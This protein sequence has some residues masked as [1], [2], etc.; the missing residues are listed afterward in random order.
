MDVLPSPCAS[1]C[2]FAAG[3]RFALSFPGALVV[4]WWWGLR[5]A[6]GP[7]LGVGSL[8][9]PAEGFGGVAGGGSPEPR[10]RGAFSM[11]S[12][13]WRRLG[14]CR[15][16]HRGCGRGV[17]RRCGRGGAPLACSL[18]LAPHRATELS[19]GRGGPPSEVGGGIGGGIRAW[20]PG[21]A[22][23]GAGGGGRVSVVCGAGSARPLGRSCG[24]GGADM[25][26][27]WPARWRPGRGSGG[28]GAL[29][30]YGGASG[31]GSGVSVAWGRGRRA[32]V[33]GSGR[34]GGGNDV[35]GRRGSG[36]VLRS[37][38][39]QGASQATRGAMAVPAGHCVV[40]T[41][42]GG[43][44]GKPSAPCESVA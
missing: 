44:G 40:L 16:G 23:A 22:V 32:G 10:P 43:G 5:G 15:W 33:A 24:E 42:R 19:Q 13:A 17:P 4:G 7:C 11:R 9:P 41:G 34:G 29:G 37:R 36:A 26:R 18:P 30:S 39:I 12:A 1:P 25:G 6:D 35:R 14:R 38:L 31:S 21:A 2:P 28:S 8:V 20:G 27:R 3:L